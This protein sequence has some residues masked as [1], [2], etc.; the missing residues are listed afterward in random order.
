MPGF[1]FF[2]RILKLIVPMN[3]IYS[4]SGKNI[5][6]SELSVNRFQ[7]PENQLDPNIN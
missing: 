5:K 6:K 7:N 2:R 4:G 1:H 3:L